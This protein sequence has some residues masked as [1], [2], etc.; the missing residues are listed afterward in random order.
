MPDHL[1]IDI[2]TAQCRDE[3]II[4]DIR[5][6]IK[7]PGTIKNPESI[8]KWHQDKAD[9]AVKAEVSKTS[10]SGLAGEVISIAWAV[11][12]GEIKSL[13]RNVNEVY[14]EADMLGEFFDSLLYCYGQHFSPVWV[15]HNIDFD[16]RFLFLRCVINDVQPSIF[17]P[18][19]EK[20]WGRNVFCTLYETMG[21]VKAGGSLD[22]IAKAFGVGQKTEGID[23]S[24]V[25][26]FWLNGRIKEIEEYNRD[27]VHLCREIYKKLNF[28]DEVGK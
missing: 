2:E 22:K 20:P 12:D 26:E 19:N 24:K 18:Y 3:R 6:N 5:D 25:N 21:L 13:A 28:I 4:Q 14:S 27:D 11:N 1:F 23:G 15:A 10:F 9:A 7:P 8:A 16:L 17:I